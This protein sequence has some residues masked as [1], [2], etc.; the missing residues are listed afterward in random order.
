M[1]LHK[2]IAILLL[3]FCCDSC[4][5]LIDVPPPVGTVNSSQV[6]STDD[7]AESAMSGVYYQMI[8]VS[9]NFSNYGM[10]LYGGIGADELVLFNQS[11]ASNSQFQQNNLISTNNVIA[12]TFWQDPYKT[13]Y[14]TNAIIS[15]LT[16]NSNVHDNVKNE[17][18]GEAKFIRAYCNFYLV[19]LFGDIPLVT[20]INW[21][22]TNL[23]PRSPVT[24]V[25]G[26]II[27]DLQDAQTLLPSDYTADGGQRIIPN[28]FAA[29]AMLARV[30]LY[31]GNWQKAA[32]LASQV[33]NNSNL[34][35]L[36][37]DPNQ[38]FLTTSNEAIWQLAQSNTISSLNA[39]PE[40]YQFIPRST[41]SQPL[42]YLTP[43]LL[44]AFE[45]NDLRRLA[46]INSTTYA[47]KIY[48]YPYKYKTGPTQA[49][50][51]GQYTEYYMVLRLAE[52]FLIRAEAEANGADGGLSAAISDLNIIRNR[53]G[54]PDYSGSTTDKTEVLDAIYHENQIEFFA[55]WGH[56]WLDLKRTNQATAILQP[57]KPHWTPAS[58]LY[59]IPLGDLKTDPNLTQNP[60]Y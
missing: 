23:L 22:N 10:T 54:L 42:V 50:S 35:T 9:Q 15:G 25:Y 53:A 34:Y 52:Q 33:I 27:S 43:Q 41:T 38:V 46:W 16:G 17:L 51:T 13:I 1:K 36:P 6:F 29:E 8:T 59:P 14:S 5:K 4:K 18:I 49:S 24:A 58:E 48:Y 37:A 11:N 2:K 30:Y 47:G 7:Q 39:T 32:D 28:K 12:A 56:R 57:L 45:P 3:L 26:S 40:G 60:G 44:N 19:N 31:L 55:E 20:S 21:R